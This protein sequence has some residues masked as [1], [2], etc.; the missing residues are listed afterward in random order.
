MRAHALRA[1]PEILKGKMGCLGKLGVKES[2]I[3]RMLFNVLA[4]IADL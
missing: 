3:M 4:A 1:A 2:C